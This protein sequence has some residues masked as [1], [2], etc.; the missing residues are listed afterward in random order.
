[1]VNALGNAPADH[2]KTILRELR[3]HFDEALAARAPGGTVTL[4]DA[5]AV[6]ATKDPPANFADAT[7]SAVGDPTPNAKLIALG[8]ICSVLQIVGLLI[9]AKRSDTGLD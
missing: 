4:Q 9:F 1:V 7:S 3:E 2:R 6:L 5:Y 8:L